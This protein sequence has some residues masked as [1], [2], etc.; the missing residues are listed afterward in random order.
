MLSSFLNY[1]WTLHEKGFQFY[2]LYVNI[3][4]PPPTS[5]NRNPLD[6]ILPKAISGSFGGSCTVLTPAAR[7]VSVAQL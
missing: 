3:E 7:G 4:N 2:N 6:K 1:I 5:L